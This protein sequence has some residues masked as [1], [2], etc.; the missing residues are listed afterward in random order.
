MYFVSSE[1]P[2]KYLYS[3]AKILLLG[4][5]VLQH[6]YSIVYIY[7]N[8]CTQTITVFRFFFTVNEHF[9]QAPMKITLDIIENN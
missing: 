2:S 3:V 4:F 1:I 8:I 7:L 5:T 6:I 9:Y